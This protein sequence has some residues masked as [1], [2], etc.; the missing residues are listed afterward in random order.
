MQFEPLPSTTPFSPGLAL[1]LRNKR[2]VTSFR[3]THVFDDKL[4]VIRYTTSLGARDARRPAPI[5]RRYLEAEL[6]KKKSDVAIGRIALPDAYTATQTEEA[7]KE[8]EALYEVIRPLVKQF[9]REATLR[10][11]FSEKV[12]A[13]A[14]ELQMTERTVRRLLLRYWYFGSETALRPFAPGRKPG[15]VSGTA[16]SKVRAL[17]GPASALEKKRRKRNTFRPDDE[18]MADMVAALERCA[19]RGP[20]TIEAAR[21][22]YL[23]KEFKARHPV[24]HAEWAAGKSPP[25]M[26]YRRFYRAIKEFESLSAT[27]RENVKGL[28]RNETSSATKARGP[29]EIYEL[30]PTGGQIVIISPHDR[31]LRHLVY[32]YIMIDQWSRFIVSIYASLM[33]PSALNVRHALRIAITPRKGRFEALG[34]ARCATR[35]P[36]G[37]V[38]A[39][40][41]VDRGSDVIAKETLE[42]A[43]HNLRIE[44]LILPPQT[45]DGKAIVE[46]VIQTLKNMVKHRGTRGSYKKF[47]MSPKDHSRKKRAAEV[48]AHSLRTVY[49][50]LLEVCDEYNHKVHSSLQKNAVLLQAGVDPIPVEA[51]RWGLE[52]ISGIRVPPLTAAD[53]TRLTLSSTHA[54]PVGRTLHRK[55]HC[56][57]PANAEALQVCRKLG[58]KKQTV[59][60]DESHPIRLYSGRDK[61]AEW[62]IDEAGRQFYENLTADE[63]VILREDHLTTAEEARDRSDRDRAAAIATRK[64]PRRATKP[65]PEAT[66]PTLAETRLDRKLQ[67][68]QLNALLTRGKTQ[69][70]K[71]AA[72]EKMSIESLMRA[73]AEL[74][75]VEA[76]AAIDRIDKR[77]SKR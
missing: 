24:A 8:V 52:H 69:G 62:E 50:L 13:R 1:Q 77:R 28:Q 4:Y 63:E 42:Q 53:I 49:R 25:P 22:E 73:A 20:T 64:P 46:R 34:Y 5:D 60:V 23:G 65:A 32:I 16:A 47:S 38:P 37:V 31:R 72:P 17:P 9:A 15:R 54:T 68:A 14:K 55:G 35:W 59:L 74:E 11:R 43:V 40:L 56:Y 70:A 10:R 12:I 2:D 66:K 76:D 57:L 44:P 36:I 33:P 19:K 61:T 39:S 75:R 6:A 7:E 18:D 41:A 71:Q 67:T 27:L 45:P 51:Y 26:A 29:G 58:T 48:A 3:I 30:D 21:I